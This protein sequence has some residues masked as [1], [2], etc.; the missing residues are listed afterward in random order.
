MRK[1]ILAPRSSLIL[2]PI[3]PSRSS[4]LRALPPS[5]GDPSS[6]A[7]EYWRALSRE[8]RGVQERP[9]PLLY[10]GDFC[11]VDVTVTLETMV[12]ILEPKLALGWAHGYA[13]FHAILAASCWIHGEFIGHVA[14]GGGDVAGLAAKLLL[15]TEDWCPL[16]L[17]TEAGPMSFAAAA[18][19][20]GSDACAQRQR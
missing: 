19:R 20:Q 7:E 4:L 13:E 1:K 10:I 14:G 8:R 16:V 11:H 18:S 5:G 3:A 6:K 15:R 9:R 2:G 12:R 17:R